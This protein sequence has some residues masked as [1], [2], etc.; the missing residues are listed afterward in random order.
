MDSRAIGRRR[1][2]VGHGREERTM[3]DLLRR[4]GGVFTTGHKTARQETNDFHGGTKESGNG[5]G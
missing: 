2:I 5:H 4:R 1:P 3:V